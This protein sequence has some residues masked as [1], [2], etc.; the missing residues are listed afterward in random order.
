MPLA[1]R[2]DTLPEAK[3]Q[4]LIQTYSNQIRAMLREGMKRTANKPEALN[5][6]A[7]F[8]ATCADARFR[9]APQAVTLAH[10]AVMRGQGETAYWETLGVAYYRAGDWKE[11]LAALERARQLDAGNSIYV[12]LFLA[13]AHGRSGDG[14]KART[15]YDS[16]LQLMEKNKSE[17]ERV[18]R[19]A[20]QLPRFRA[21]AAEVLAALVKMQ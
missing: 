12:W 7:W 19:H 17:L 5:Q 9:D 13:M 4:P 3:R 20:E 1:E 2:D 11:S 14:K 18:K 21:E 6:F 8:L 16:A 15:C 10:Q